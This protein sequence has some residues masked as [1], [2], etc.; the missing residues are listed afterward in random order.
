MTNQKYK[1]RRDEILS[2]AWVEAYKSGHN[3]DSVTQRAAQA[4]DQLFLDIVIEAVGEDEEL[5]KNPNRWPH[6]YEK[7][8]LSDARNKL[9]A[10]IR[11]RIKQLMEGEK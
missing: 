9:K 7:S 3:E 4:L 10:E 8:I 2:K 1:E 5:P 11:T 6:L